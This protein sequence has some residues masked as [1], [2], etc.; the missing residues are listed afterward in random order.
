MSATQRKYSLRVRK[1]IL[2]MAHLAVLGLQFYYGYYQFFGRTTYQALYFAQ[3]VRTDHSIRAARIGWDKHSRSALLL[4]KRFEHEHFFCFPSP[5]FFL[6]LN[7]EG[8]NQPICNSRTH[9]RIAWLRLCLR[10]PP[11]PLQV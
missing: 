1:G 8:P 5:F 10:G 7:A 9:V 2:A 3:V 11:V 4:D 6:P